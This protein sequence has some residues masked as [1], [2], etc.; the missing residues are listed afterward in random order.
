MDNMAAQYHGIGDALRIEIQTQPGVGP[1]RGRV[2]TTFYDEGF[3]ARNTFTPEKGQER[4]AQG[5]VSLAGTLVPGRV[6]FT[7][8]ASGMSQYTS[9]NLLAVLPDRTTLARPLR[10]PTEDAT[11]GVRADYAFHPDHSLRISYDRRSSETRNLGIGGFNLES[12]AYE[13]TSDSS[14]LR[15]AESG[16]VGRRMYT[17]SRLQLVWSSSDS[18]SEVEIPTARVV[19]AFTGGGAQVTGGERSFALDAATDLDYVRGAHAWRIGLRV[20]GGRYT[21]D[22]ATNYLGTYTFASLEDFNAGRPSNF[23]RRIGD[24][25]LTN[26]AWQAGL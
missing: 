21:S 11:V 8:N 1:L 3:S 23:T 18:R 6:S 15:L 17:D 10:R 19:G 9:P 26:S 14:M 13:T 2:N 25:N 5:G 24:P 16:P 12:R 7:F 22:D 20:E 4:T